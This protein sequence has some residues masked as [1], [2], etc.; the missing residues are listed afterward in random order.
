MTSYGEKHFIVNRLEVTVRGI[1]NRFML[2]LGAPRGEH[3]E[4]SPSQEAL[5]FI[6]MSK[7]KSTQ[8]YFPE[9]NLIF[10]Y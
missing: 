6:K 9:L 2:K 3:C 4:E 7:R 1:C 8:L 5:V 10:V